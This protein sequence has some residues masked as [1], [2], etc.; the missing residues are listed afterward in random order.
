MHPAEALRT[1][2]ANGPLAGKHVLL[3]VTGSIAAVETVKLVRE[4]IRHGAE[5]TVSMTESATRIIHPEA[6]WFAS[7]KRVI[8][9]LDGDVQH[10]TL[11]GSGNGTV[12]AV[13]VAPCSA[14]M[15]SK[16]ATGI[17][18]DAVSTML[19]TAI[20]AGKQIVIAPSMHGD[21]WVNKIIEQNLEKLSSLNIEIVKPSLDEGKAKMADIET[22]HFALGRKVLGRTLA[23]RRISVIGGSTSEPVDSVRVLTNTSTGGTATALAKEAYLRGAN[24]E[25]LMGDCRV[26]LPKFIQIKRFRT[27][28]DLQK[29]VTGKKFD[30]VLMPA[31]ISDYTPDKAIKGK[32]P[33]NK[34]SISLVLK[35]TEKIIDSID[36]ELI[37]GFKLEVGT[38][39]DELK[40]RARERLSSGKISAIV[41]NRLEDVKEDISRAF[42]IDRDGRE[43]EMFGTRQEIARDILSYISKGGK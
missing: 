41:A 13:L 31:A 28:K 5:V 7:G 40:E 27:V 8:T 32:M 35:K 4:L 3:C 11:C 37:I 22:I 29:L 2:G 19:V 42:L 36:A 33:S 17:C 18:D 38:T 25:L 34:D 21:M 23:G 43:I 39:T 12:D 15:I 1:A 10:V 16:I 30:I 14:D 24:V 9:Q 6:L 26:S 20:G